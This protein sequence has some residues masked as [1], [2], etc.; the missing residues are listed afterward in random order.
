MCVCVCVVR[1]G[2]WIVCHGQPGR[3]YRWGEQGC[4][5][6]R[7]WV[8]EADVGCESAADKPRTYRY[9]VYMDRSPLT[10]CDVVLLCYCDASLEWL[11]TGL[12]GTVRQRRSH[13]PRYVLV[14]THL[15]QL[16]QEC[17]GRYT[18]EFEQ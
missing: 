1:V 14:G 5:H 13:H 3:T 4:E 9:D 12:D 7:P 17:G 15:D 6:L 8:A 18:E 10:F 16:V 2:D 11:R